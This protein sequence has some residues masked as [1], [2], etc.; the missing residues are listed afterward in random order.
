MDLSSEILSPEQ[1]SAV[2]AR[3]GLEDRGGGMWS[4]TRSGRPVVT[5]NNLKDAEEAYEDRV[6]TAIND[7]E[8]R[9]LTVMS[10]LL[11]PPNLATDTF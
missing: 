2:V 1:V 9:V 4:V 7:E 10:K 8:D 3:F 5:F 6:A 11:P